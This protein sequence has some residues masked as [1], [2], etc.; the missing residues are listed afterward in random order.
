MRPSEMVELRRQGVKVK[1]IVARSGA[2]ERHVY[3]VMK[4]AGLA[5]N[6]RRPKRYVVT[7]SRAAV[8]EVEAYSK[9]DAVDV[10]MALYPDA[11]QARA[12][13]STL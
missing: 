11:Y 2:S 1:D 12:E 6:T 7:L 13:I 9:Q 3:E 4:D 10:A 8:T 5:R